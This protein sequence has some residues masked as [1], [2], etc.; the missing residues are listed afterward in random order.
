M[1]YQYKPS[2]FQSLLW[3]GLKVFVRDALFFGAGV[4]AGRLFI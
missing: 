1:Q 4:V 2:F 3:W